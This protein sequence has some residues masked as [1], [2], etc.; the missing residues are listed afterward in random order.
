MRVDGI[1]VLLDD[2]VDVPV[3]LGERREQ[4]GRVGLA[5]RR[6]AHHAQRDGLGE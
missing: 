1:E 3:E 5:E 6:L 4:L 2:G